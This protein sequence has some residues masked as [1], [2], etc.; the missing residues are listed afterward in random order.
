MRA[1]FP[2]RRC[3]Q[4]M[5]AQC[6]TPPRG[7]N[8]IS[9][10]SSNNEAVV[11]RVL[12]DAVD[13][14]LPIIDGNLKGLAISDRCMPACAEFV[15]S[16]L[17][18][19]SGEAPRDDF[20]ERPWFRPIYQAVMAWY[21]KR[22]GAALERRPNP[23]VGAYEISG[24]VFE[25]HVPRTLSRVEK[26]GETAWLIFPNNLQE[27]EDPLDWI[28][29]A[30]NLGLLDVAD[31]QLIA[32]GVETVGCQLRRICVDLMAV[33]GVDTLGRQLLGTILPH[34]SAAVAHLMDH[35]AKGQGLACWDAHQA[36]EK[37][38]KVVARQQLGRHRHSHDVRLLHDDIVGSGLKVLDDDL[39]AGIP[40]HA[41]IVA[42]RAGE[43]EVTPYEAYGIYRACL[44]ATSK[45]TTKIKRE[46]EFHN[47]SLLFSKPHFT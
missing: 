36:I 11:F 24:V 23:L 29:R 31:R 17:L 35:R 12:E 47:F 43:I 18:E 8:A 46:Y 19:V 13:Y 9:S 28:V 39:V 7:G 2:L 33:D 5:V 34:L 6:R 37:A 30:P 25:L 38:L 45:C 40:N 32:Q 42:I 10:D 1:S 22:Y 4:Q 15:Q 44:D 16:A 41:D 26:E 21:C 14:W 20:L 27:G 3:P